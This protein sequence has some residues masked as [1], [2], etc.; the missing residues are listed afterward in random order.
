VNELTTGANVLLSQFGYLPDV[1]ITRYRADLIVGYHLFYGKFRLSMNN[2]LYFDHYIGVGPGYVSLA[3]GDRY[4]IVG[5]TGF[6]FWLGKNFSIRLGM[7]DYFFSEPRQKKEG[8]EHN[9]LGSL[10]FGYVF[11]G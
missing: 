10:D 4:A 9:I 8:F 2:V 7:K 3:L 6:A 5:E 1:A 11:G